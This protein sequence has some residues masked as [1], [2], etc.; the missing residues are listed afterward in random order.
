MTGENGPDPP[1][2]PQGQEHPP[3]R[4]PGPGGR[5]GAEVLA[6]LTQ[7]QLHS[8]RSWYGI[9]DDLF[10]ARE[11]G[12]DPDELKAAAWAL[13]DEPL[14]DGPWTEDETNV[15]RRYLG[16][17]ELELLGRMIGR[18]RDDIDGHLVELA[19]RLHREP[20]GPDEIV[21]FKRLYGTRSDEDLALVFGR[22]LEVVQGLASEL[23][24][25]K[26]KV[27]LRRSSGGKAKTRMP[28]WSDEELGRLAEMYPN[29]SNLDIAQALGRSVKSVV[30]KAHN[31]GLKKDKARLQQMGRQNVRMRYE[32]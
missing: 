8:L 5:S 21:Q 2:P 26:D 9:R 18:S 30:S 1:R 7:E 27:F 19:A 25:S 20:L 23:C 12:C 13:F 32:R 10:L 16:A 17:V 31:L 3:A 28:R 14:R 11:L 22:Q 4:P 15:L 24:L 29:H 6:S